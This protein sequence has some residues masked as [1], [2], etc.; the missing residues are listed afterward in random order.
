MVLLMVPL[1]LSAQPAN[2]EAAETTP[3]SNHPLLEPFQYSTIVEYDFA[4][5]INHRVV[6]SSLKRTRGVVVAENSERI[7][8]NVTRIVYE[9]SQDFTGEDVYQFFRNQMQ[10]KGYTEMFTCTGRSCGSSNYW[11]NDIF[12]NRALYG[13]QNNQYYLS[14]QA[15]LG[16]ETDPR[17]SVYVITRSNRRTYAYIE[18]VET[19]TTNTTEATTNTNTLLASLQSNGSIILP[20]IPFN[21]TD[22]L[23][24]NSNISIPLELMQADPTL[25]IYLVAHLSEELETQQGTRQT[26]DT[27]L[28]RSRTRAE[29]LRTA[30]IQAGI[31]ANRITAT[32]VGPLSPSCNAT[33][34]AQRIE[35]VLR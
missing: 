23:P 31:P 30:L 32:G 27:L 2:T 7:R 9:V 26:L 33:S 19:E 25:S 22:Q 11:A 13:P 14:M 12:R 5:D 1:P 20:P 24:P 35:M 29:S 15:P 3:G 21:N 28:R 34:C 17:L 16:L 10:E 18:V 8:G 4:E 6:L